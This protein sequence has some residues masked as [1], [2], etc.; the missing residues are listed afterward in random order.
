M[1]SEEAS[2]SPEEEKYVPQ[3]LFFSDGS[4]SRW[5]RIYPDR[6]AYSSDSP[7]SGEED[8]SS[9]IVPAIFST[10]N[11]EIE[12]ESK[13]AKGITDQRPRTISLTNYENNKTFSEA[14]K[15]DPELYQ[16]MI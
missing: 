6:L 10:S 16:Y 2:S 4:S 1:S 12:E 15:Q 11:D 9:K 13:D 8:G 7:Q 14:R 5:L 3:E